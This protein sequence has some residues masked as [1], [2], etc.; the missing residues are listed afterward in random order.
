MLL[1]DGEIREA[2]ASGEFELFPVDLDGDVLQPSSVDLRLSPTIRVQRRE[3]IRGVVVD[4]ETADVR[5]TLIRFT[6]ETDI[7]GGW[8][9]QPGEFI[10]GSTVETIRLPWHLAG[11]VE[12]RS[13]LAR[14]GVGV[15]ITAPKI[16]PGYSGTIT[17][18]IYNRGPWT[19]RLSAGMK[20]C[21]VAIE[22]LGRPA[23][24]GY[25]GVFGET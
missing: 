20:I 1:S 9:F 5:D 15:H 12:G 13:R 16:D 14:L 3:G 2:L 21:S 24:R 7:T 25:G 8:D 11:R 6:D 23:E 4:P 18:E 22:R 10:I 17:L 19:I